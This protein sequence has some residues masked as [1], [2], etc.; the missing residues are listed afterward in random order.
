[1]WTFQ[2]VNEELG[3]LVLRDVVGELNNLIC[4]YGPDERVNRAGVDTEIWV[5]LL[6]YGGVTDEGIAL[7]KEDEPISQ[8]HTAGPFTPFTITTVN[9]CGE[10]ED[11]VLAPQDVDHVIRKV[12]K[13]QGHLVTDD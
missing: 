10:G 3:E 6:K 11:P 4:G 2:R 13:C 1:M 8:C 9:S 7:L 5:C 12:L